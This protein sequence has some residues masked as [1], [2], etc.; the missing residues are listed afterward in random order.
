MIIEKKPGDGSYPSVS[1][2]DGVLR[3][4]DHDLPLDDIRGD[5]EQIVSLKEGAAFIANVVVPPNQYEL[6][7]TGDVDV[8]GNK[9][10]EQQLL[11]VDTERMRVV[12]WPRVEVKTSEEEV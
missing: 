7:D 9:I 10:Y 1:L 2:S 12:L 3:V 4:G 8:D 5:T 11:P 6:V